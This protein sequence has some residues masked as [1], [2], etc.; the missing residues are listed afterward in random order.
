LHGDAK[1]HVA[2]LSEQAYGVTPRASALPDI[3]DMAGQAPRDD[4]QG[5]NPNRVARARE[6]RHQRLG[7]MNHAPQPIIVDRKCGLFDARSG[8]YL[9]EGDSL[10]AAGDEIDFADR[11]S[12]A[13][14]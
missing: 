11:S 9:Y 6:T 3:L 10:A 4:E 8:L 5:V 7:R 14:R 12:H 2:G 13:H 1:A